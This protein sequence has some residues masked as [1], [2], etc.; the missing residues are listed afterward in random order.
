LNVDKDLDEVIGYYIYPD[1][2]PRKV[3][4]VCKS[5]TLIQAKIN[6]ANQKSLKTADYFI[7]SVPF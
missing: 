2:F 3:P 4:T 1:V 6:K 7:S 5:K